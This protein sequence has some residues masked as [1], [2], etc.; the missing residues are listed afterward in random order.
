M[1]EVQPFAER[2]I[3]GG[4]SPKYA[5]NNFLKNFEKFKKFIIELPDKTDKVFQ[6]IQTGTVKVDIEDRDVRSLSLEIDRSSNRLAYS[7][8]IA[9]LLITGALL[10]NIGGKVIYGMSLFSFLAFISALLL[11]VI[12]FVSVL[13]EKKLIR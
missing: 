12:L 3:I 7:M 4:A 8:I 2:L 11:C 10:I 13:K 9:S 6:K 5:I 1:D